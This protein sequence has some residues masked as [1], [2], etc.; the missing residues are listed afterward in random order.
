MP[1][2]PVASSLHFVIARLTISLCC[3]SQAAT[4][5]LPHGWI[6][7]RSPLSPSFAPIFYLRDHSADSH[8]LHPLYHHP[9]LVSPSFP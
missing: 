9:L 1:R 7:N 8:E 4:W 2:T 6:H 5:R 3:A